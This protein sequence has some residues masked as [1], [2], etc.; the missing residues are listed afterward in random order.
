[1]PNIND[2]LPNTGKIISISGKKVAVFNNNGTPKGFSPVC[3]HVGCDIE[4][5]ATEKIWF[6]P[7]HGSRFDTE[8]ALLRGPAMNGLEP[9]GL[10]VENDEIKIY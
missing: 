1:M 3:P 6:C 10:I 7:C 8:G 5:H 9:I 4:W 2:I